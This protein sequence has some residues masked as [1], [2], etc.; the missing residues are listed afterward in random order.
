MVD[1]GRK[2][3]TTLST[4]LVPLLLQLL[5]VP[6]PLGV[7]PD[8]AETEVGSATSADIKF[9]ASLSPSIGSIK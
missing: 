3:E 8:G 6:A 5:V 2:A 9:G 4:T 1:G 7:G